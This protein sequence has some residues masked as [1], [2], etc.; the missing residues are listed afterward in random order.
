MDKYDKIAAYSRVIDQVE[1]LQELKANEVNEDTCP[2]IVTKL[3]EACAALE[4][5]RDA[6]R[7]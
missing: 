7:S 5:A 4:D 6:I 1:A 2:S 3:D